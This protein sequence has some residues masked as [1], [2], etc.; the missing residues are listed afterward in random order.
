V[1]DEWKDDIRDTL[2]LLY[3]RLDEE[4]RRGREVIPL[5]AHPLMRSCDACGQRPAERK[6]RDEANDPVTR[7][8][9]YC[10]VCGA[11]RDEDD[12]V[13]DNIPSLIRKRTG[14]PTERLKRPFPYSWERLLLE[15][16][17]E[18]YEISE[19]TQR[20]PDFNEL[21]GLAGG[22][23]YLALIYA[24]GN[25]MGQVLQDQESLEKMQ[26]RAELIDNAVYEAI[27]AAVEKH[28]KVVPG[29]GNSSPQ[30]PFDLLLVG[31]DDIA[32]VTPAA[33]AFDVA[34]T[35][36]KTFRDATQRDDPKKIGHT[37]SIG[38]VLAPIKYPFGLLLDLAES[39]LKHAKRA[40]IKRFEHF[41]DKYK[42]EEKD[43]KKA[44]EKA[45][46]KKKSITAYGDTFIN[47]MTVTG[48]ISQDFGE[49]FGKLHEKHG[50]I[51]GGKDAPKAEFYATLRPYT[52]E[53]LELLL[54]FIR[55]G[56]KLALGRTKLHQ[57]REAILQMNLTTSVTDTRA[58]LRNWRQ[59]QRDFVTR[60]LQQFAEHCQ[61]PYREEDDPGSLFT[62]VTFPWF[63]NGPKPPANGSTARASN[64]SR[65]DGGSTSRGNGAGPQTDVYRTVLLDFVELFDFVAAEG[66]ADA[67]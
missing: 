66:G 60:Y 9:R 36:A 47:F 45:N 30:F 37:L 24:D 15:Q 6:D 59:G 61:K 31:G 57:V 51:G 65:K 62:R 7:D 54:D 23:D 35:I 29:D 58:I 18:T 1:K 43:P 19:T 13:R 32:I 8:N 52:V 42:A 50:R 41:E 5:P 22:K 48:S 44:E 12:E 27:G 4:Q 38:I 49:V 10:R 28:L 46:E 20:P 11:K 33:V 64:Q 40:G 67:H 55:E 25:G 56:R 2:D 53:E 14:Q 63:A 26:E 21:R 39:T 3:H 34:L 16:L 17:P